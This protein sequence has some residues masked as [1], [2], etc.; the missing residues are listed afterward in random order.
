MVTDKRRADVLMEVKSLL[1]A[2]YEFDGFLHANAELADRLPSVEVP[3]IPRGSEE[4][5]QINHVVALGAL[6]DLVA[7]DGYTDPAL[8]ALWK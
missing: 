7:D 8:E 5:V 3:D 2:T 6:A 1:N 4:H